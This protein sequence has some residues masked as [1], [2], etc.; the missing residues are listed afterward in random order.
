MRYWDSSAIVAL[1]VRQAH[2]KSV[3]QLIGTD[4]D[5]LSWVLSDIEV[6]SGLCRLQREG[7]MSH[8]ELAEAMARVESFWRVVHAITPINAVKARAK[9]LL[10]AHPLR[11]ADAMQ[12]GAALSAVY[13][14]PD[15]FE[16]VCL[17][18]R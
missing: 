16:F 6:R 8:D 3:R 7:S 1:H 5:C 17:D 12:L 2:S 11:A 15:G 9:R 18:D 4:A 10:H 14:D 13:D